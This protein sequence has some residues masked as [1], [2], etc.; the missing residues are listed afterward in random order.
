MKKRSTY[1][2]LKERMVHRLKDRLKKG[3]RKVALEPG[4]RNG[5]QKSKFPRLI[6]VTGSGLTGPVSKNEGGTA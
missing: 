3:V 2:P 5:M 4:D 1:S 6:P